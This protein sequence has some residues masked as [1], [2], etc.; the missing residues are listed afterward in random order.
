MGMCYQA[1]PFCIN[2][3]EGD[4]SIIMSVMWDEQLNERE[5]IQRF[6][7]IMR[8]SSARCFESARLARV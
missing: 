2:C 5:R 8:K 4:G 3:G 6:L 1:L 7:S